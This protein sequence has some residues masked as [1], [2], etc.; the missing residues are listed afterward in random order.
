MGQRAQG[1]INMSDI[2]ITSEPLIV[3]IIKLPNYPVSLNNKNFVKLSFS[4]F[5]SFSN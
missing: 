1:T 2:I 4:L 3:C 5:F